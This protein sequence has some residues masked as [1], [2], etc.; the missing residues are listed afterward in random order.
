VPPGGGHAQAIC[1]R[2]PSEGLREHGETVKSLVAELHI[3]EHTLYVWRRR[4]RIDAGERPGVKSLTTLVV[5]T[6]RFGRRLEVTV[7]RTEWLGEDERTRFNV[8]IDE[9][10]EQHR[11]RFLQPLP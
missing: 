5:G 2:V 1:T 9:D 10:A 4:A 11:Q 3:S 8:G 6:E 7:E